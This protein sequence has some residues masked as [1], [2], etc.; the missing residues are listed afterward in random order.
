MRRSIGFSTG[1][2]AKGDFRRGLELNRR[3]GAV[4]AVEL[5]ALRE[6]ELFELVEAVP[7][8][9]LSTLAYVSFHAPSKLRELDEATLVD[10][11]RSLPSA[12]PIIAHPEIV[13]SDAWRSLG[14]RLCIENMD[15][16][17]TTGRTVA[18]MGELLDR[19]P[20]AGFCLD[21]GH[22]RQI[23]PTMNVAVAMVRAF[24][25][26]LRQL[27]VSEVGPRGEHSAISRLAQIAFARVARYVPEDC[28]IIIESVVPE[29]EV[30]A[31]LE[32]VRFVFDRANAE[33]LRE[34]AYA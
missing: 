7:F 14:S 12:W 27:H 29:H 4:D 3:A 34:F 22:A 26:R 18:E 13:I 6:G 8:L 32:T 1:A 20:E 30:V 15:N 11:L 10:V 9:D 23:D 31:E 28:P 25:H 16:R 21:L 2:V 33:Q 24:G 19:F 5:S 17:K